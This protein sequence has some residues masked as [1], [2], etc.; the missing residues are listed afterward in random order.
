MVRHIRCGEYANTSERRACEH[1]IKQMS[2]S[3]WNDYYLLTNCSI[4]FRID[5]QPSEI[6]M[7]IIGPTGVSVIEIKH[8]NLDY[9]DNNSANVTDEA[10][11]LNNKAKKI[12]GLYNNSRSP[13]V[14]FVSGKFLLTRDESYSLKNPNE[15]KSINGIGIFGIDDWLELLYTGYSP[16][17]SKEEIYSVRNTLE[18]KTSYNTDRNLRLLHDFDDLI[19][20][21]PQSDFQGIVQ[22]RCVSDDR[23]VILHLYDL[24]A[25]LDAN[26]GNLAEREYRIIQ[27]LQ[28]WRQMPRLIDT[29][30]PLPAYPGEMCFFSYED[31]F[32]SA[33]EKK[34]LH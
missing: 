22:G 3:E 6:D 28:R 17:L 20:V 26:Q 4:S 7:L 15:H 29:F 12:R 31:R 1:M 18:P 19:N 2:G 11:K 14:R 13:D 34:C 16:F 5:S 25:V 32:K 23:K 33:F 27:R 9:I 24:S 8:W 10:V 21:G 30:Q